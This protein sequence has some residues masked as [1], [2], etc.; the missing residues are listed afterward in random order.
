MRA[1][2]RTEKGGARGSTLRS[3]W[4]SLRTVLTVTSGAT[5]I[6]VAAIALFTMRAMHITLVNSVDTLQQIQTQDHDMDHV[7]IDTA[8]LQTSMMVLVTAPAVSVPADA[9]EVVE[10]A[11]RL[12]LWLT[13]YGAT[14]LNSQEQ[15]AYRQLSSLDQEAGQAQQALVQTSTA[16]SAAEA[17]QEW[18]GLDPTLTTMGNIAHGLAQ[19]TDA[20]A[21]AGMQR[22]DRRMV[23][24][25]RNLL[26]GAFA[27][28]IALTLA[29]SLAVARIV[30]VP[31][32]L[33][34]TAVSA[35]HSPEFSARVAEP[36]PGEFGTLASAFNRMADS[37][38]AARAEQERLHREA[39]ELHEA[40]WVLSQRQLDAVVRAHEEERRRLARDLHD[41][42]AQSLT[43]VHLGLQRLARRGGAELQQEA[44]ELAEMVR[45]TTSGL[46]RIAADLRPSEL[47][48]MGLVP[49]LGDWLQWRASC[50]PCSVR[51]EVSGAVP[52]LPGRTEVAVFRIVQEAMTNVARHAAAQ[53]AVVRV[54]CSGGALVVSVED[55]GCGFQ[56]AEG[57]SGGRR[58][59]LGLLGMRE[60]ASMLGGTLEIASAP[61]RGTSVRLRLPMETP[62]TGGDARPAWDL[63]WADV[64]NS[65]EEGVVTW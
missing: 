48:E 6:V 8:A 53:D 52:R 46:H 62:S 49:A 25:H 14:P 41:E 17:R 51:F 40:N 24:A 36:Q 38:V 57:L 44:K 13:R 11:S 21:L 64:P 12:R 4:P 20:T 27:L 1:L 2:A 39:L 15:S 59:S 26:L 31:L 28:I 35:L 7:W 50:L 33:L 5:V 56:P 55:D 3:R 29:G 19:T 22:V 10:D 42:A 60:R 63:A 45:Q 65:G 34:E 32:G 30:L 58:A 18:A 23:A 37:L 47:D 9:Q 16:G 43:V 61:G 54:S